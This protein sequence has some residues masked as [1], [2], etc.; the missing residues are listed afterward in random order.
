M[1]KNFEINYIF[2]AA[3]VGGAGGRWTDGAARGVGAFECVAND[4]T[5][6]CFI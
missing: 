1:L 6:M 2:M 3:T 4:I 5:S